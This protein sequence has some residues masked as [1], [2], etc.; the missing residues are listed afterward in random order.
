MRTRFFTLSAL[1]VAAIALLGC[2][3]VEEENIVPQKNGIPFEFTASGVDTKTATD[4]VHTTW[5]S[6]DKVNLFHAVAGSTTYVS[7]GAFT[8][9]ADGKNVKFTGT[10]AGDLT[11]DKYDWYAIYPYS[12]YVTTPASTSSGY[13]TIGGYA[14]GSQAQTGNSNMAHIAGKNYPVAGKVTNVA[15]DVKPSISLVPLTTVI[16]VKVTNGTS[17]PIT[18]S[19]VSFTGTENIVGQYYVNFTETPV[20]YTKRDDSNVSAT[21]N[22]SVTSGTPIAASSSATFYLAVKPFT[23]PADGTITLSVTAD[24]GAQER[25]KVLASATTFV[26]GK[27]NTLNFTY[28]KAPASIPEPTS[29]TGWYRVEKPEWL[30]AGDHVI[31]A[32]HDG[33]MAMSKTQKNNNRDGVGVTTAASG[34]YRVLTNNDNVQMFIL[35]DGTASGSFA[36]WADNGD[37]ASKYMYAASSSSNYLRFQTDLDANASFVATI[38]DGLGNLTAQGT[39]TRKVVQW[40]NLFGCYAAASYNSISIYK[41]YGVW[42]GSTTCADPSI[43]QDGTTVTITCATPGVKIYYTK[44]GSTPTTE[45]TLYAAPFNIASPVTVKAI[46]V[47]SHYTNSGVVSKACTL[48]V[49]TTVITGLGSSFTITCATEG[50]TIYYET[51]TVD[52]ASVSTPTTSSSSYSAAVAITQTTYVKAI[53]VK[54]GY[55][56][57]EVASQTCDY[58]SAGVKTAIFST[59]DFS[60][61]GTSSTGSA[62]SA[63]VDGITFACDKGYGTTQIRCYK[64][65]VITISSSKTITEIR[66]TFSSTYTGGM[67]ESYTGLSTTSWTKELGSQARLTA[68]EVDYT[69]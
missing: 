39:N 3:K 27:I 1:A 41:Y 28:D 32:N 36:F 22:L 8:A 62:I 11:A 48:K 21:A 13:I 55:T 16:A 14:S 54:A 5:V 56:D 52:M 64:G 60:G 10:L 59:S 58:S 46:A 2:N 23:A 33:T 65:G 35:D 43:T 42:P 61:Q 37:D 18:V 25:N 19:S 12:S 38:I 17:S 66:F 68:I 45:S 47:R 30:A 4:G 9:S 20:V 51:S 53:A 24:N 26:A 69:E 40:N 50:A 6:G 57:S 34:D 29:E 49:A 31:I 7:D 67:S 63:T 44:D 15:K